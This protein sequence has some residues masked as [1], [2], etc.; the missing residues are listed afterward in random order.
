M[1]QN[2]LRSIHP[3]RLQQ[4]SLILQTASEL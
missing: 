4:R 3:Q 2:P 1:K